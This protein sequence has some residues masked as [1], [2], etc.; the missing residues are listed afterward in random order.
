MSKLFCREFGSGKPLIILHGLLGCSDNWI[1]HG[2]KLADF[3]HVYILDQM[4]HGNSPHTS[5]INYDLLSDDVFEFMNSN[6]LSSINLMGHSMGG[7]V[8]MSFALKHPHLV[9]NLIILDIAPKDYSIQSR[10]D[11][12]IKAVVSLPLDT[13]KSRKEADSYLSTYI[14]EPGVRNFILKNLKRRDLNNFF[15]KPNITLI[16]TK[17]SEIYSWKDNTFTCNANTLFIRGE[18]SDYV[19][20]SDFLK[21]KKYF[22]NSSLEKIKNSGHWLHVDSPSEFYFLITKFLKL[23]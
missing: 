6:K 15:W 5:D 2:K 7:K 17:M 10:F 14:S 11:E 4:N 18:K 23:S 1:F 19:S 9:E 12:L 21:I 16:A 8:A 3:F 22:P 13:I 20:N